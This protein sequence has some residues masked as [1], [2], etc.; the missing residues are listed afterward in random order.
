M[1]NQCFDLV[2]EAPWS[3]V[4]WHRFEARQSGVMPPHS[5]DF[6][7]IFEQKLITRIGQNKETKISWC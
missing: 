2:R 3:A 6:G 7:P 5:K 4:P 1:K